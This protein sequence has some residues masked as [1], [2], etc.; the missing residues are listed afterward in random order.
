MLL[1]LLLTIK[2][3][4]ALVFFF[5]LVKART[6]AIASLSLASVSFA[7]FGALNLR[8]NTHTNTH[9]D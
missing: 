7:S 6:L 5:L 2:E 9:T 1:L 4:L 3:G 8:Q